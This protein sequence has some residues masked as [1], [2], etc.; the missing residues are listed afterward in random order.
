MNNLIAC[1]GLNCETCEARIATIANDD[2]LRQETADK[3]AVQ[4]NVPG[5]SFETINCTGCRVEGAKI[6]HCLECEVRN[7]V[8]AQSF[9]TCADCD[10]LDSCALVGGIHKFAPDALANL[11]SLN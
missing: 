10:K 7:C 3:W 8:K 6:A 11:K 1:C 2:N 4:F 5:I 9:D